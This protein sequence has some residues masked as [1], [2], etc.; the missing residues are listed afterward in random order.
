MSP[1]APLRPCAGG[2]GRLVRKGRCPSC[3]P[4]IDRRRGTASSRGYD[5][6]WGRFRLAFFSSLVDQMI[7]PACGAALPGGPTTAH[8]K[9]KASGLLT[10]ASAD[11][12]SLHLDHEPPLRDEERSDRRAVCDPQRIQLLCR[13]C[14]SQKDAAR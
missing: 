14:H 12:S 8:S 9:C 3:A 11:G 5:L 6:A 2:C 13:E 1:D 4:E 10:F 7:I